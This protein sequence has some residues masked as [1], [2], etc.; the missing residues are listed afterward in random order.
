MMHVIDKRV[1]RVGTSY[2]RHFNA[3]ALR[4]LEDS[5]FVIQDGD[6]PIAVLLSYKL[7]LKIQDKLDEL[8]EVVARGR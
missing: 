3:D 8:K 1:K 4:E 2:L 6:E 5:V 7:F